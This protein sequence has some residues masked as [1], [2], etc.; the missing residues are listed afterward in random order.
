MT[1]VDP[2]WRLPQWILAGLAL[3]A[4]YLLVG[5][6]K[7]RGASRTL[8]PVAAFALTALPLPMLIEKS[9]IHHLSGGVIHLTAGIFNFFGRPVLV[10]GDRME[11][12]GEWVEVADGCSGIAS[13]PSKATR[14]IRFTTRS[15]GSCGRHS[16]SAAK[17][18][19][20]M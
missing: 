3:V 9:L 16:T 4:T 10:F 2:A 13:V 8:L 7:G 14:S 11:S 18:R 6:W 12:L 1:L 17:T 5:A 20:P 19:P 15:A